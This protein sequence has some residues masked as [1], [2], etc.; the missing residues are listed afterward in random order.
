MD[1]ADPNTSPKV[2]YAGPDGQIL[3]TA[4]QGSQLI[5]NRHHSIKDMLEQTAV[6][7]IAALRQLENSLWAFFCTNL[8]NTRWYV[9]YFNPTLSR[10]YFRDIKI[11]EN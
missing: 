2:S 8:Q 1:F 9:G 4:S 3:S 5:L 10:Y 7:N 11:N 6:I